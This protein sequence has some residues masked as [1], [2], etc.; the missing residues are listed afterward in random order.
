[1]ANNTMDPQ[2]AAAQAAAMQKFANHQFMALT[3]NKEALAPQSN[4][5]ALNQSFSAGQPLYYTVPSANNGFMTGF[6]V[7][8]KL[9]ATMAAGSSATYRLNAGAPLTLIDSIQ[10]QYGGQQHNFRPYILKYLSQL[11]GNLAQIQPRTIVAGQSDTY[12]QGYYNGAPFGVA[13]GAN[14]WNFSFYVPM[15]ILHPQD[16]R[17]ILPIQASDTQCQIVVNCANAPYGAD[18]ILSA[19]TTGGSGTGQAVTV[20]GTIAVIIEYK[21]GQSYSTTNALQPNLNGVQTVQILRDSLLTN[22][23]AQQV[24]RQKLSFL[25]K[26]AWVF[27]TI[28]DG[29]QSN[30]YATTANMQIIEATADATG[31]RPF[32]RV[33]LNTNLDVREF[34]NDLSGKMGGLLGQDTD[35]GILPIVYAPIFQQADPSMLEGQH[36]LDMSIG[37]GWTDFHYGVQLNA[38]GAVS[39]ISPRFETHCVILNDPLVV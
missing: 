18:P 16:V 10:V 1:M 19:V 36:Y 8:C 38:V 37:S 5:G 23:T 31:N 39:G 22:V 4:G 11:R 21:D 25:K 30:Q 6:W 15:N 32:W 27:A 26:Y 28:V 9:T 2:A 24:F 34:Y 12:L 35:E 17:G 20:T 3:V 14:T 7:Q 29:Q 13:V 33:G